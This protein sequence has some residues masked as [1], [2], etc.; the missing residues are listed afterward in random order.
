MYTKDIK[1][2]KPFYKEIQDQDGFPAEFFQTHKE[3]ITTVITQILPE[4][5]QR[6]HISHVI[7]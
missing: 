2:L 5:R 1:V 4:S 7:S 3:K 6:K